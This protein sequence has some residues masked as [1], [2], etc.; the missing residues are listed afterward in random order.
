MFPFPPEIIAMVEGVYSLLC[1]SLTLLIFLLDT[2]IDGLD[3]DQV[4]MMKLMGFANFDSTKVTFLYLYKID[5]S[6]LK[7]L[8]SFTVPTAFVLILFFFFNRFL[9]LSFLFIFS[10][11][12][13]D[14]VFL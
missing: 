9:F 8:S 12:V 3:D 6:T 1:H 5:D 2:Q 7:H 10:F 4:D 14:L 11:L 13:F